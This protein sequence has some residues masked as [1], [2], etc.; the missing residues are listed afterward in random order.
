[1]LQPIAN[2]DYV[3]RLTH[4]SVQSSVLT[5]YDIWKANTVPFSYSVEP[6]TLTK[7]HSSF[8][9]PLKED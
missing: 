8:I 9:P 6:E 2:Y 1:M 3:K 4:H 7:A 5:P